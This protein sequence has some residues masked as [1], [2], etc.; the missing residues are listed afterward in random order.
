MIS[1]ILRMLFTI[2][3]LLLNSC[4]HFSGNVHLNE[5][6]KNLYSSIHESMKRF[7]GIEG[8]ER[9]MYFFI[10]TGPT[11]AFGMILSPGKRL[12]TFFTKSVEIIGRYLKRIF[13]LLNMIKLVCL[14]ITLKTLREKGLLYIS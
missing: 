14:S 6:E 8:A 11:L 12:R 2:I 3:I 1:K 7:E 10:E 5:K 9:H 4:G 13:Q